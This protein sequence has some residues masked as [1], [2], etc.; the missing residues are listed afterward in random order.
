[1]QAK[2]CLHTYI[3]LCISELQGQKRSMQGE[4]QNF[5]INQYKPIFF[6]IYFWKVVKI[7]HFRGYNLLIVSRMQVC[8]LYFSD[9]TELPPEVSLSVQVN[10]EGKGVREVI[11]FFLKNFLKNYC[12]ERA[13]AGGCCWLGGCGVFYTLEYLKIDSK[14]HF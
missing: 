2:S 8:R 10:F 14:R 12:E 1:M 13:G 5:Y 11:L 4:F 6:P 9:F 3:A 7:G